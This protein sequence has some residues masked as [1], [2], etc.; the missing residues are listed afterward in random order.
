MKD[1]RNAELKTRDARFR[2]RRRVINYAREM[3]VFKTRMQQVQN[4]HFF[5]QVIS[6]IYRFLIPCVISKIGKRDPKN[7]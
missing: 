5:V 3:P 2:V 6:I 7:F 1:T 4:I